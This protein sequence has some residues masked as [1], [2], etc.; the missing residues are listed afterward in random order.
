MPSR[1]RKPRRVLLPNG[2]E[3]LRV[4][5]I[6]KRP[7]LAVPLAL[8]AECYLVVPQRLGP[9][10]KCPGYRPKPILRSHC[11]LCRSYCR[12]PRNST[13][14]TA[15]PYLRHHAERPRALTWHLLQSL[16][17]W[18]QAKTPGPFRGI[19]VPLP[20]AGHT[21]QQR[22]PPTREDPPSGTPPRALPATYGSFAP[23]DH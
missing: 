10:C 9:R 8:P 7:Q 18:L 12:S 19:P 17:R 21:V 6:D 20:R 11:R 5:V 16:T 13:I 1:R 3:Y 23:H 14:T 2:V 15:E 4:P 22:A